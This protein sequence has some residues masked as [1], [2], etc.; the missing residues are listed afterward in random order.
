MILDK[1]VESEKKKKK[2]LSLLFVERFRSIGYEYE[3]ILREKLQNR[4]IPFIGK[5][6]CI[7]DILFYYV[8]WSAL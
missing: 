5:F 2:K 8:N 3:L 1:E 4:G 7:T 6:K